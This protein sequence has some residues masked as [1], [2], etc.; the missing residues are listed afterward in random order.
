ML[1]TLQRKLTRFFAVEENAQT[2]QEE[3]FRNAYH[4]R[5]MNVDGTLFPFSQRQMHV[6]NSESVPARIC[7]N[8]VHSGFHITRSRGIS[9]LR[10]LCHSE[11]LFAE[12]QTWTSNMV[13]AV[14]DVVKVHCWKSRCKKEAADV[15]MFE[16]ACFAWQPKA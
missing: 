11:A 10:G 3:V 7:G 5:M 15:T 13:R 2:L 6:Q 4:K 9:A 14:E 12:G 1:R 8:C 16:P